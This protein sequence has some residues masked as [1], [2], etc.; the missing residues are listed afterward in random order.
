MA[1]PSTTPP[2]IAVREVMAWLAAHEHPGEIIFCTFNLPS[3]TALERE[4]AAW[5]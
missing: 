3:T 2:A 4:L 1:I 5:R